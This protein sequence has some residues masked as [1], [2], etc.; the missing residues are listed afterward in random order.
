MGQHLFGGLQLLVLGR[1]FETGGIEFAYLV[2]EQIEFP[3]PGPGVPAEGS[4]LRGEIPHP[5]PGPGDALDVD[6]ASRVEGR[7]LG[8]GRQQ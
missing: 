5:A 2:A 1:R 4:L 7:P 8:G 6:V 3:G